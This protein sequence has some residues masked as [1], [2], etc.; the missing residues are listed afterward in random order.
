MRLEPDYVEATMRVEVAIRWRGQRPPTCKGSVIAACHD[1]QPAQH[2]PLLSSSPPLVH[3]VHMDA[4]FCVGGVECLFKTA[5]LY[6]RQ[7][8]AT[9]AGPMEFSIDE[10]QEWQYV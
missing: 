7:E 2:A 9:I 8:M 1:L 10:V 3:V 4:L 6:I 5:R